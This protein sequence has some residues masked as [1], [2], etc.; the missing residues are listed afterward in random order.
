MNKTRKDKITVTTKH[1]AEELHI[2]CEENN[3][4]FSKITNKQLEEL[5]YSIYED[6]YP[7]IR[8]NITKLF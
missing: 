8:K 4:D 7:M 2:Y 5:F 1:I 6:I 3:I